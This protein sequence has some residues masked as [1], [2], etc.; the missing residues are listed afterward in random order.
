MHNHI[1]N[2]AEEILDASGLRSIPVPVEDIATYYKLHIGKAASNDFSGILIRKEAQRSLA[3][4][5][6]RVQDAKG[7]LSPTKSLTFFSTQQRKC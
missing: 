1:E 5:V 3:S 7:L 2:K 4:T 6:R